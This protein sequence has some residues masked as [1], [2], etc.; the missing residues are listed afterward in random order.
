MR[1][2][3]GNHVRFP[4]SPIYKCSLLHFTPSLPLAPLPLSR[5]QGWAEDAS[6]SHSAL[7]SAFASISWSSWDC[8]ALRVTP[9]PLSNLG[10]YFWVSHSVWAEELRRLCGDKHK[11]PAAARGIGRLCCL[12]RS[13][14]DISEGPVPA[15]LCPVL[16]SNA[17]QVHLSHPKCIIED[18]D[19]W[20][21]LWPTSFIQ[22]ISSLLSLPRAGNETTEVL[23]TVLVLQGSP[24]HWARGLGV[25]WEAQHV[26]SALLQNF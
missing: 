3:L 16:R 26:P 23:D 11:P 7:T 17:L 24:A 9:A 1:E 21:W 22:I 20:L 25:T 14:W 13:R 5:R 8:L 15:A 2:F 19:A 6:G 4:R 12:P 10:D 18:L